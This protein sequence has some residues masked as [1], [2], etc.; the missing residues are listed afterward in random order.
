VNSQDFRPGCVAQLMHAQLTGLHLL[1]LYYHRLASKASRGRDSACHDARCRYSQARIARLS[2]HLCRASGQYRQ[3]TD[4]RTACSESDIF[5]LTADLTLGNLRHFVRR[6]AAVCSPAEDLHPNPWEL[7]TWLF[8]R[9]I[10]RHLP[11]RGNFRR[12][13]FQAT[14]TGDTSSSEISV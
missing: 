5:D 12:S 11:I 8:R 10:H 7:A 1:T 9:E 4:A 13:I 14:R 3:R 2:V 6:Q